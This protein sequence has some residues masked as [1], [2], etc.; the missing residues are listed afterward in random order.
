MRLAHLGQRSLRMRLCF[1][2]A[3]SPKFFQLPVAHIA[4]QGRGNASYRAYNAQWQGRA[5][6]G[7]PHK[8]RG[9]RAEKIS[10]APSRG[11]LIGP[12]KGLLLDCPLKEACPDFRRFS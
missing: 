3:G 6:P 7:Q 9:E 2:P 4:K 1:W 5:A 8:G 11:G 10:T 12:Y